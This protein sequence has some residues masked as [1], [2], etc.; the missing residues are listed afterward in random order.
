MSQFL[1]DKQ[2]LNSVLAQLKITNIG[3]MRLRASTT[4]KLSQAVTES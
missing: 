1:K 3:G 2:N 4:D